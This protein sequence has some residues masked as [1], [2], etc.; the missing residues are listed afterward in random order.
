MPSRPTD[1]SCITAVSAAD[2]PEMIVS[3]DVETALTSGVGVARYWLG[4]LAPGCVAVDVAS[5][6]ICSY[7][8]GLLDFDG[9][10]R[11]W[12]SRLLMKSVVA[13]QYC[14]R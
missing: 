5:L 11:I 7:W 13:K 14:S 2:R 3:R 10:L 4:S 6:R 1:A 12:I 8:T 9:E